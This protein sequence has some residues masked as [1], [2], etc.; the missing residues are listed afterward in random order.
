MLHGSQQR[1]VDKGGHPNKQT[2]SMLMKVHQLTAL[3][4]KILR[5]HVFVYDHTHISSNIVKNRI[6]EME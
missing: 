4:V 1:H 3:Y 6:L 2:T 5:Y